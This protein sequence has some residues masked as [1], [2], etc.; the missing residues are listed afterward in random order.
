RKVLDESPVD[1]DVAVD[2]GTVIGWDCT[3]IH[4]EDSMGEVYVIVV[5]PEHQGHGVGR[6]LMDRAHARVR[7]AGMR[8]VMVETGGDP[9]HGAARRLYEAAGYQRSPVARYFKD[10]ASDTVGRQLGAREA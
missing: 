10:L 5:D 6:A 7:R 2:A 3:R 8:M 4:P 9:G 1:G